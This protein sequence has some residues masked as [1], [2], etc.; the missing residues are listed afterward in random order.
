MLPLYIRATS[1]WVSLKLGEL[2]EYRELLYFLAARDLKFRY[3]QTTLGVSWLVLQPL[4]M[5]LVFSILFGRLAGVSPKAKHLSE[6][7]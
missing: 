6:A 7:F 1:G 4:L 5:T 3:K 2:W